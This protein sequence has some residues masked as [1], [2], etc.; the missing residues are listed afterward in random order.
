VR[1]ARDEYALEHSSSLPVSS[2][3]SCRPKPY[4]HAHL[5]STSLEVLP[6][7][8]R[9]TKSRPDPTSVMHASN[10]NSHSSVASSRPGATSTSAAIRQG[11]LEISSP[12]PLPQTVSDGPTSPIVDGQ[13]G[14][15]SSTSFAKT[16]T[17]PR[18][19]TPTSLQGFGQQGGY[20]EAVFNPSDSYSSS[21][22]T[23]AA[24]TNTLQSM[25]SVPSAS[26]VRKS[27]GLR[28]TFHRMFGSK[29]RRDSFSTGV[30]EHR[31]VGH[32]DPHSWPSLHD[33]F[34]IGP[35]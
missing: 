20:G 8:T 35:S 11:K 7:G 19:M 1:L 33:P 34:A 18:R 13:A 4:Y 25:S 3:A 16:D 31:M 14:Y 27:G 12:I 5:N 32:T 29:R 10:H 17:W 22:R 6:F 23:S 24:L 15:K 26:S 30:S 2:C 28:A 9:M 21:N